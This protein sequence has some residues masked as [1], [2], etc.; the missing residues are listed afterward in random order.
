MESISYWKEAT[1]MALMSINAI[2]RKI[3]DTED[4]IKQIDMLKTN[5]SSIKSL[6]REE[7][8]RRLESL[9]ESKNKILEFQAKET[10]SLR[11]HGEKIAKGKISNRVLIPILQGFQT[12]TESIANT[13]V[14][15]T[16]SRGRIPEYAKDLTDFKVTQLFDGSFGIVLEREYEQVEVKSDF[17]KTNQILSEFFNILETSDNSQK[18]IESIAPFGQRAIC[19]YREWL[20]SMKDNGV[21]V[22]INWIDDSAQRRQMNI[23]ASKTDS[24]IFTLSSID[25]ITNEEYQLKGTLTGVNVRNS[26]FEMAT[27]NFGIIKGKSR[28]ETLLSVRSKLGQEVNVNITKSISHSKMNLDQVTWFL[29]GELTEPK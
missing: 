9:L 13:I 19:H 3:R 20:T 16:S 6:M 23:L 21:N 10:V 2:D 4:N 14:N 24:I 15:T 22:D 29:S 17:S 11:L 7:L 27:E 12:L 8:A 1:A 28:L 18:L 25:T 5:N 26:T